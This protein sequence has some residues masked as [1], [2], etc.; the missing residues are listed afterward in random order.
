MLISHIEYAVFGNRRDQRSEHNI[1]T[2]I[3]SPHHVATLTIG[4][5]SR[6]LRFAVSAVAGYPESA[7][8]IVYAAGLHIGHGQIFRK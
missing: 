7:A 6:S 1:S 2:F 8:V 5:L 4:E 3:R